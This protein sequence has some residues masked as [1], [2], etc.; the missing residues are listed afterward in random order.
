M[1]AVRAIGRVGAVRAM[2]AAVNRET[3]INDQVG[4]AKHRV[5]ACATDQRVIASAAKQAVIASPGI[6]RV[7]ARRADDNVVIAKGARDNRVQ[8]INLVTGC[9][10]ITGQHHIIAAGPDHDA[11]RGGG[12]TGSVSAVNASRIRNRHLPVSRST[13]VTQVGT[14][15]AF[16]QNIADGG[17]SDMH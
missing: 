13:Q 10:R 6:N 2:A 14:L 3:A 1:G 17:Q 15:H 12:Q 9:V 11:I 4:I 5:V 8:A 16:V 7:I